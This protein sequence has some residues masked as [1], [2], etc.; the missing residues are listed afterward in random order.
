MASWLWVLG[1][2]VAFGV[3]VAVVSLPDIIRY[4]RGTRSRL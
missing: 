3:V 2:V 4:R 1:T